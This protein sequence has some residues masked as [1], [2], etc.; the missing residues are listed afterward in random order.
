LEEIEWLHDDKDILLPG[1][2]I[3][4]TFEDGGERIGQVEGEDELD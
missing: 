3:R 2:L 4:D 1:C